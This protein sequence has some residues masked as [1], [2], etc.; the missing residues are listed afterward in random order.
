MIQTGTL[1]VQNSDAAV[2]RCLLAWHIDSTKTIIVIQPL[3]LSCL[4]SLSPWASTH[5]P[6][7]LVSSVT[8]I[9][10]CLLSLYENI[11]SL[12]LTDMTEQIFKE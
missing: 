11:N 1:N 6:A 12:N 4:S 3:D 7:R 8:D 5:L 2:E 10:L 9:S